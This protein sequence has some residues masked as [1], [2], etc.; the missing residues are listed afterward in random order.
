[1]KKILQLKEE[2]LNLIHYLI[3]DNFKIE[4]YED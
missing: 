3:L 4:I 2:L 1:M